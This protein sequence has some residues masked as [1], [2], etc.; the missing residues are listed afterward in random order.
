M[1]K[2]KYGKYIF[3][4]KKDEKSPTTSSGVTSV[5]LPGIGDWGGIQHRMR[6][7]LVSQPTTIVDEPHSHDCDEYLCFLSS[8][9]AHELD[10][11]A[12]V[13][14]ALGNEKER[15][16]ITSPTVACV[17]KGLVHGPIEFRSVSKPVL[18]CRIYTAPDYARKPVKES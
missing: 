9:P 4:A 6:W 17:P 7:A 12:E 14:L 3:K 16:V 15:Q 10:F 1:A 18:F 5:E 13:E 8:D 2:T 11:G